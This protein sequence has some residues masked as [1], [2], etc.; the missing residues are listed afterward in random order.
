MEKYKLELDD[1]NSK[2][3]QIYNH[4]KK[5]I[6]GGKIKEHEKLP[7][8]RKLA[9]FINVNNATI[10]KVYELLE[11]EGYVYKIIGSG[12]FVSSMNIK[13][14]VNL[15]NYKDMIHFDSGNPSKDMF[16][17]DNFK[18]AINMALEKDGAS[19]FEY[20]E[21][22]GSEELREELCTYLRKKK[23]NTNK[24]NIQIISGAQQGIDIVCK[25]LINYSD[26]VFVE[27]PTYNG[28][29]EV[30]KSRGAKIITIPMLDDGIDIGILKLKLEKIKPKLIYVMPNFQNPSGIS[31]SEYKKKKLIELSE[32][33]DFYIL[34]DDFISDFDFDS[35]DSRPL[36]SYDMKNR[37]IYIK[38]FSK[39]LMPGLR[40]GI[41]DI[42]RELQKKILWAKYSSDI[43][44]P[45]LI[46]KSMYYYMKYFNWEEYLKSID[47]VY[48]KKYRKT[49]V[50]LEEKLGDKLKIY[51]SQGGLNFF[52]ELPRGYSSQAFYNFMLEKGVCITP[53]T[54]FF[55]NIMDD[56]FFRINIANE[57]IEDI[58]KGITIIENNLEE[59]ITS[60]KNGEAIRSNKIFY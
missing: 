17:L 40:I 25:G 58:E 50:L 46:Q 5:M 10:V 27:E 35:K 4:I 32:E 45:G 28:A 14:E 48:T 21:G 59:F 18:A 43:S 24:N 1:N 42:P 2:Y 12:T 39:I 56:R 20:D 6:V 3:I 49:K 15:E 33:Y 53:G 51:K 26:V 38:S 57:T 7:P 8:I 52:I 37:V 36:K 30:F 47:K 19:I 41:V 13:E 55:D 31:Y 60:Y 34:E 29:L 22:K 23:I 11:K 54:Y 16:P 44:T 9:N